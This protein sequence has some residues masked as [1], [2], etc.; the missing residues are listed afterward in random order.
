M[1]M[2]HITGV[3][4]GRV[5]WSTLEEHAASCGCTTGT[6]L[7]A[8]D[9]HS[10]CPTSPASAG[11]SIAAPPRSRPGERQK[12]PSLLENNGGLLSAKATSRSPRP[13]PS[14]LRFRDR[15]GLTDY[16]TV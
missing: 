10:G 6:H 3:M 16:K 14:V 4:S 9:P 13:P 5:C 12:T 8:A 15:R 11:E 7:L 1:I 2:I